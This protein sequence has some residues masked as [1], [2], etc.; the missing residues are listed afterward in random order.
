VAAGIRGAL[1][2]S[3]KRELNILRRLSNGLIK[4]GARSSP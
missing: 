1:D 4:L 3:S 2:A